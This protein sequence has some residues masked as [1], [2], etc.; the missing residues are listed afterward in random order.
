MHGSV[1]RNVSRTESERAFAIPNYREALRL[2]Q[3][4]GNLEH[5]LFN[6]NLNSD[7]NE[8]SL[9]NPIQDSLC[10]SDLHDDVIALF[11]QEELP[12]L[13]LPLIADLQLEPLSETKEAPNSSP[14]QAE[15]ERISPL[16]DLKEHNEDLWRI[17]EV[18]SVAPNERKLLSWEAFAKPGLEQDLRPRFLTEAGASAFDAALVVRAEDSR[19]GEVPGSAVSHNILLQS[20]WQLGHGRESILFPWSDE[21][22][23]FEQALDGLRGSGLSVDCT[24]SVIC[25]FLKS[26]KDLKILKQHVQSS[27]T[28]VE[29]LPCSIALASAVDTVL[30]ICE[31]KLLDSH[32]QIRTLLQ[33]QHM[34]EP[35]QRLVAT[36][37]K[38][39]RKIEQTTSDVQLIN[40][41]FEYLLELQ[42]T[43]E[44]LSRII[45][46][47]FARTVQPWLDSLESHIG[48]SRSILT[49]RANDADR[50]EMDDSSPQ[51]FF[52]T[53]SFM[54][55]SDSEVMQETNEYLRFI[56]EHASDHASVK[57][58]VAP[59][60]Q[61]AQLSLAFDWQD[62]ER[63][64]E[65]A[66]T[67]LST[68]QN[69]LSHCMT[70]TS[71]STSS[72][73]SIH[74]PDPWIH[75]A[76]AFLDLPSQLQ[77]DIESMSVAPMDNVQ[78]VDTSVHNHVH[79]FFDAE[80][81]CSQLDQ[82]N[83]SFMPAL[84]I[85]PFLYAQ[86][87]ALSRLTLRTLLHHPTHSLLQ[88]LQ[89]HHAFTLFNSGYLAS[90]LSRVLFDSDISSAERS[91]SHVR[92][93]APMGLKLG[94]GERSGW[95]PASSE[96]RLALGEV[97]M[98]AWSHESAHLV[99]MSHT[100]NSRSLPGDMS[101]A[102]RTD[103]TEEAVERVLD[104][105]SL[106]AL[107][108]LKLH[109][110]PPPI[111]ASL[112]TDRAMQL[113]DRISAFWLKMLRLLAT[114][115]KLGELAS[116]ISQV[117]AFDIKGRKIIAKARWEA[118][119]FF[120]TVLGHMRNIGVDEPWQNLVRIVQK[121]TDQCR[122]TQNFDIQQKGNITLKGLV[123]RHES[124]LDTIASTLLLKKKQT[125]VMTRLE[126]CAQS[127]LNLTTR[128][129]ECVANQDSLT[130]INPDTEAV[131]TAISA[132]RWLLTSKDE[133]L[134]V[135][136]KSVQRSSEGGEPGEAT[137]RLLDTLRAAEQDQGMYA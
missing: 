4:S 72:P 109:Y 64:Q 43:G 13:E 128:L 101:F 17:P 8:L 1:Y 25:N 99:D 66:R 137:A 116:Q 104:S 51:S 37:L 81:E 90:H 54:S 115:R 110:T 74:S 91:K 89:A 120:D 65:K 42:F 63:I 47:I 79:T 112:F 53:P 114:L 136:V 33:L 131:K 31:E 52:A 102:I 48:L 20:L 58:S 134:S 3:Y 14:F 121:A 12:K 22:G 23:S 19:R 124:T 95:P 94:T 68:L 107:D 24:Q 49:G 123:Q 36:L 130:R 78:E 105:N 9:L 61:P 10:S 86:H 88:H 100:E 119:V 32:Q 82:P 5:D 77:A 40:Q 38:L 2:A 118:Q 96:V 106:H 16:P 45:Q 132:G 98:H 41:A 83:S 87:A 129:Q 21:R 93:G 46:Y 11:S 35:L 7:S 56:R 108:F 127:V 18:S 135:S 76:D 97:L 70:E 133:F 71:T 75:E 50:I 30:T 59:L 92:T 44:A 29:G 27:S 69:A 80:L 60:Q 15:T 26:G 85:Q 34:F 84:S 126:H 39:T 103:L 6:V 73:L 55:A 125:K 67:H 57:D 122:G 28:V 62:L 113:Y 111:F 117:P